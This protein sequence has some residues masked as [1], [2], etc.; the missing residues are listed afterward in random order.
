MGANPEEHDEPQKEPVD[1]IRLLT[2]GSSPDKLFQAAAKRL[3][4]KRADAL[5]FEE[6]A[7][8]HKKSE[9]IRLQK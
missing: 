8:E 1:V 6:K 3:A 9:V 7:K 5:A 2:S 4:Q